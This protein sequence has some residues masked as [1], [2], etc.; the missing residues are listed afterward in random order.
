MQR[1]FNAMSGLRRPISIVVVAAIGSEASPTGLTGMETLPLVLDSTMVN[2]QTNW[3]A[4]I[5]D[6][7]I[8]D[9]TGTRRF[10]Y[11]L[12]TNNLGEM[13]HYDALKAELLRWANR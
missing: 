7:D 13:V 12:T 1:E 3:M 4:A 11:N 8:L 6:V 9:E 5:R 2:V 10:V